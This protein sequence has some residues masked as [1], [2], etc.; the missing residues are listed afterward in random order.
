MVKK[1]GIILI[2]L[3]MAGALLTGCQSSGNG[4]EAGTA[5]PAEKTTE[6]SDSDK[7]LDKI[8]KAYADFYAS[9]LRETKLKTVIKY[10]KGRKM[11]REKKLAFTYNAPV[12]LTFAI[13][14]FV[15]LAVIG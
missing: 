5:A 8:R 13:I 4:G 6:L 2:S 7:N 11:A 10:K 12:T 15:V 9:P 14:A 3:C 1:A